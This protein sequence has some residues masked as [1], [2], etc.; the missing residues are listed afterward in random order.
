MRVPKIFRAP[1]Y[2]A[3]CAVIFAIAQLS[4]FIFSLTFVTSNTSMLSTVTF[5]SPAPGHRP[6]NAKHRSALGHRKEVM[7]WVDPVFLLPRITQTLMVPKIHGVA[8]RACMHSLCVCVD[9]LLT[10]SLFQPLATVNS[11][12]VCKQTPTKES[13][14]ARVGDVCLQTES[15]ST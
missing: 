2:R 8:K 12:S 11:L 9:L 3:H 7:Q 14:I 6:H 5:A 4:C 10:V 13:A 1:I 15:G